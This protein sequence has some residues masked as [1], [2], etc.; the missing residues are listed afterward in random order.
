MSSNQVHGLGSCDSLAAY[1]LSS[2]TVRSPSSALNLVCLRS[3]T[4]TIQ[5]QEERCFHKMDRNTVL[6]ASFRVLIIGA[7]I[8]V[9]SPLSRASLKIY[10]RPGRM[11]N[12]PRLEEG[13]LPVPSLSLTPLSKHRANLSRTAYHSRSSTRPHL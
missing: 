6:E 10:D 5:I 13:N 12:C 3:S 7:G 11:R 8:H 9:D 2:L 1:H 4:L